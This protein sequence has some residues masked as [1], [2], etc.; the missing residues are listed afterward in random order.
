[1]REGLVI[2]IDVAGQAR[3]QIAALRAVDG[4]GGVL[5]RDRGQ[6]DLQIGPFGLQVILQMHQHLR[7]IAGGGGHQEPVLRQPY[8]HAIVEHHAV[9]AQHQPIARLADAQFQPGIGIDAIQELRRVWPL[10]LDLT[11][12]GGIQDAY[13][14]AGRLHLPVHG[15]VHVFSGFR[16]IPGAHPLADI[17]ELCAVRFVP[18][19]DRRAAHRVEQ[20]ADIAP[21]DGAEGDRRVG[22][23]ESGGADRRDILPQRR[24][25]DRQRVHIAG[26]A[27]IGAHAGCGVALH[28][29]DRPEA[30][31]RRQLQIGGGHIIL[32][33]DEAFG[34]RQRLFRRQ[35]PDGG[36]GR[37]LRL[38]D[39][40]AGCLAGGE[41]GIIRRCC[42][43]GKAFRK[44]IGGRQRAIAHARATQRLR[45]LAGDEHAVRLAEGELA[46]RLREQADIGVPAARYGDEIAGNAEALALDAAAVRGQ[47]CQ[48][49][50]IDTQPA[51]CADHAM[52]LIESQA[53]LL[54]GLR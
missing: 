53:R 23:A 31:A 50:A 13:S 8:R 28:M 25:Q 46:A 18:V 36:G 47:F 11:E 41:A 42:P 2:R 7:G 24:R 32:E 6:I 17:L 30:L 52:T 54:R 33:I 16:I 14:G 12:G 4:D 40:Q 9:L 5:L 38:L 1:M 3:Q 39:L 20:S 15:G 44:A 26:A 35:Q 27:L 51:R 34:A 22:R 37:N 49:D 21:G 48:P 10:Y 43:G 45:C 29:L 19:M